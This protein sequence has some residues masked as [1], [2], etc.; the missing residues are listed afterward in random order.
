MARYIL[1]NSNSGYIWGDSADLGGKIFKGNAIQFA[2]A[3]DAWIGTEDPKEQDYEL[4]SR[5]PCDTETGYHV[6]RANV[7]RRHTVPVITNGQSQDQIEA[8]ERDCQYEG[9][10]SITKRSDESDENDQ[11]TLTWLH[12][13]RS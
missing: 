10:I 2:R 13:R 9:F 5:P 12:N 11:D 6:Y 3:L 4:L 8:V 7:G 1:I